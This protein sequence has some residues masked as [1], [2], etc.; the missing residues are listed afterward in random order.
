[1]LWLLYW[2]YIVAASVINVDKLSKMAW[3]VLGGSGAFLK[4]IW[5]LN[6]FMPDISIRLL[7]NDISFKS[8]RLRSSPSRR[9]CASF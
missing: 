6:L 2:G 5:W 7:Y 4:E 1:M 3:S 9:K 8:F